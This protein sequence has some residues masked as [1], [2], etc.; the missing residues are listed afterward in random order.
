M[1]RPHPPNG[2]AV[3]GVTIAA[4][5]PGALELSPT[6]AVQ[7]RITIPE[8]VLAAL[9]TAPVG[10]PIDIAAWPVA[11]GQRRPVTLSRHAVVDRRRAGS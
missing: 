11:P 4:T 6:G 2:G 10:A 8:T 7:E 3:D 1:R 5:I 9:A